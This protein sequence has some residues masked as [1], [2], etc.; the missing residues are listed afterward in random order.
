MPDL[1]FVFGLPGRS[2]HRWQR[3]RGLPELHFATVS[4]IVSRPIPNGAAPR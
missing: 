2:V 3:R 1:P 4:Y